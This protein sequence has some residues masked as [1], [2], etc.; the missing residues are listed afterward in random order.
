VD[1]EMICA[2][3]II[4]EFMLSNQKVSK[5]RIRESFVDSPLSSEDHGFQ[6]ND[7]IMVDPLSIEF[8]SAANIQQQD[9]ETSCLQK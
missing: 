2:P 4:E 7:G 6:T 5:H 8:L 9:I 3:S 1:G